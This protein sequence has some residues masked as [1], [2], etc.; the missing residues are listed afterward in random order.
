MKHLL[1]K[2][3]S[4]PWAITR[5]GLDGIWKLASREWTTADYEIFH[6]A[7]QGEIRAVISDLGEPRGDSETAF[8]RGETGILLLDGPIIPRADFF[9]AMSGMVSLD[10]LT[11]EFKDF[12]ADENIKRIVLLIDSPGGDVTGVS[13]FADLV[14]ASGTQTVSFVYG[15]AASAAYWIATAADSVVSTK[16]GIV[17]SIG[18]VS[19]FR[20]DDDDDTV[21]IISDQSPLKRAD[22]ETDEGRSSIQEMLND[23]ADVF[24]ESVAVNMAVKKKKVLTDFGQGA[25]IVAARAQAAGMI[26]RITTLDAL[27]SSFEQPPARAGQPTGGL[28][29][30]GLKELLAQNPEAAREFDKEVAKARDEAKASAKAEK[31]AVLPYLAPKSAYGKRGHALAMKVLEG[32]ATVETMHV[33]SALWDT[34]EEEK[35]SAAAQDETDEIGETAAEA[36]EA[37]GDTTP[38]ELSAKAEEQIIAADRKRR[39]LEA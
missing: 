26:D 35:N 8:V 23:L 6:R 31:K 11:A 34:E 27:L 29:M 24:I 16:T 12:E 5:D 21:E 39:G 20:K 33:F 15:M 9:S 3:E 19:I 14:R 18:V 25:V 22:P 4:M 17:G 38:G 2:I 37:L 7:A 28:Q 1:K 30:A 10:E 32:H 13:D 36:P